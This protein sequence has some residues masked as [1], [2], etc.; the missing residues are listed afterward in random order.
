MRRRKIADVRCTGCGWR[1]DPGQ[2]NSFDCVWSCPSCHMDE[3]G[4]EVT[5]VVHL[6]R[7]TIELREKLTQ[8]R[9]LR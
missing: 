2:L 6:M 1:G 3:S 5:P 9:S 4:L 7:R 8:R